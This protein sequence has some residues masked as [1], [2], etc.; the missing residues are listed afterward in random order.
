MPVGIL[1]PHTSGSLLSLGIM[2]GRCIRVDVYAELGG[3]LL[4]QVLF[5]LFS[6]GCM[7]SNLTWNHL[8]TP[9]PP[10]PCPWCT[11]FSFC[12]PLWG[13]GWRL[14]FWLCCIQDDLPLPSDVRVPLCSPLAV[15][16][17]YCCFTGRLAVVLR[18][19]C[20]WQLRTDHSEERP[21]AFRNCIGALQ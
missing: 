7:L 18:Q 6:G 16:P 5:M 4:K 12:C 9:H 20:C 3:V 2:A 19:Q 17:S 11:A 15:T 1:T 14:K 13:C 10:L 8:P 21:T